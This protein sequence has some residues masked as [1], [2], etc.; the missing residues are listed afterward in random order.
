M[1]TTNACLLDIGA[2]YWF[3]AHHE[4]RDHHI[5]NLEGGDPDLHRPIGADPRNYRILSPVDTSE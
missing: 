3:G 1:L 4:N 5:F 2:L